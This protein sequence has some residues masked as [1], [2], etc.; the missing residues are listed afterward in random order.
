MRPAEE[1]LTTLLSQN[2]GFGHT[3]TPERW[4][5]I[6]GVDVYDMV[7][8]YGGAAYAVNNGVVY[9]SNLT[10]SYLQFFYALTFTFYFL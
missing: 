1:G 6:G 4:T 9:F 3:V 2:I 7:H 10:V 5:P 8:E